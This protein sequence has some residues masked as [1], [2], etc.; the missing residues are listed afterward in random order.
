MLWWFVAFVW[1]GLSVV[2]MYLSVVPP[3]VRRP[4]PL[5]AVGRR[6]PP[7]AAWTPIGAP[8]VHLGAMGLWGDVIELHEPILDAMQ[9]HNCWNYEF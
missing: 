2:A 6:R 3:A 1:C 4:L 7:S 9:Q 5:P 8:W